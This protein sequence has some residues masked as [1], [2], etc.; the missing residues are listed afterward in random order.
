MDGD[1]RTCRMPAV[2][3]EMQMDCHGS[4]RRMPTVDMEMLNGCLLW[5]VANAGQLPWKFRINY[6]CRGWCIPAVDIEMLNGWSRSCT[7][8]ADC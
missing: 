8:Y 1:G 7:A 2:D 4:A 6:Q 3:M 5:C